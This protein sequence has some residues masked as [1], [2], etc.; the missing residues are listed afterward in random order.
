LPI[1]SVRRTLAAL[2]R[3]RIGVRDAVAYWVSQIGA[4][5]IAALWVHTIIEPTQSTAT[6]HNLERPNPVGGVRR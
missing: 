5:L 2:I 4:G 1:G 6:D 3:H